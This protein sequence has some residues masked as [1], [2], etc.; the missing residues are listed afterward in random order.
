[1]RR[2]GRLNENLRVNHD[3][4]V[5]VTLLEECAECYQWRST[6]DESGVCEVCRKRESLEHH[7][8]LLEHTYLNL[9][10]EIKDTVDGSLSIRR[11]PELMSK[12]RDLTRP[13]KPDTHG[14]TE[15]DRDL[16]LDTWYR[17]TERYELAML[18]LDIDAT[19]QKRSKWMKKIKKIKQRHKKI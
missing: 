11:A 2:E 12:S 15:F 3:R 19:K 8:E 13:S 7:K 4:D 10:Q 6:C 5:F 17:D 18:R 9:P 1:M 16:A 14:M